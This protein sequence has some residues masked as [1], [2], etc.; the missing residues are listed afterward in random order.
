MVNVDLND[1]SKRVDT[2]R[3]LQFRPKNLR[4]K[5]FIT[6]SEMI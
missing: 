3:N 4:Q 2:E 5:D 6:P 1:V